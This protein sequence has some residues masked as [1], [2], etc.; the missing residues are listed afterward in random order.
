[1]L[2]VLLAETAETADIGGWLQTGITSAFAAGIAIYLIRVAIPKL[3]NDHKAE[4][5]ELNAAAQTERSAMRGEFTEALSTIVNKFDVEMA[6][7]REQ[8]AREAA[9]IDARWETFLEHHAKRGV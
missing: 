5:Q 6:R 8:C 1:M 9:A 2:N 7:Q 3:N 4:R